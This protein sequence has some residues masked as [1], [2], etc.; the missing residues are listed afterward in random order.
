MSPKVFIADGAPHIWN[1]KSQ[2]RLLDDW[3]EILDYYH[4]TEQL[5]VLAESLF[6]KDSPQAKT[7][8]SKYADLLLEKNHAA[9]SML[10]SAEY[11]QKKQSRSKSQEAIVKRELKYFRKNLRRMTYWDFRQRGL[12]IGSGPVESA[13]K[14]VVKARLCGSGMRWSVSGG[15][16]VLN[17]RV[18]RKSRR[19]DVAWKYYIEHRND[20]N[21]ISV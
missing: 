4:A 6:G 8:Y 14:T 10:R 16:H 2:T 20:I 12:P 17:L 11:Y 21:A 9:E 3:L 15:Q 18:M 13:C 1:Y 5:N 19:W 7:W